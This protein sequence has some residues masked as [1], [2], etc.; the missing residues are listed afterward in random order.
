MENNQETYYNL[1]TE[2]LNKLKFEDIDSYP[3]KFYHDG[4]TMMSTQEF[5]DK[6]NGTES[7]QHL[8]SELVALVGRVYS[9]RA[10][11]K[12]LYFIDLHDSGIRVQMMMNSK[13][14]GDSCS[15]VIK[16]LKKESMDTSKH[17][18]LM[19]SVVRVGDNVGVVGYVFKT[20]RGELSLM[21]HNMT[22]LSPCMYMIPPKHVETT[23]GAHVK[24][25]V[26]PE[27][28]FRQRYLDLI[29]N[30]ENMEIFIRRSKIIKFI[31]RF[32][33]DMDFLEVDTPV[34]NMTVGGANAKPFA[35]HSNDFNR[36]MF[37]RIAPEL[38][39]K[40]LVIGGYNRVYE[41]GR[42]FRNEGNDLTH[43]SEF[44]SMECYMKNFD[45]NDLMEFGEKMF[46][47][48]VLQMNGSY[49]V[50]Y[51]GKEIDFTPPF[52]RIDM[53][54]KLKELTGM[55]MPSD[56]STTEARDT[57][58]NY[59]KKLGVDCSNPRTTPRLIDKLVGHFIEP[60][61]VNPTFITNHPLIMSPLAKQ[62]RD[63]QN[64]TERF[65]LF[66]NC[67]E[68]ANAYT[69]LNDPNIQKQRFAEQTKDKEM[70]DDE[71][72]VLD[73]DF[74]LALEYGLPPTG[75]FGVG[76][77]RLCMLLNDCT[78]IREVILFPTMKPV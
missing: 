18:E 52:K 16:N 65:E 32:L 44:T 69:E 9:I 43:N 14:Y 17:F 19:T 46:A 27:I 53:L 21:I 25:L 49:L 57:L 42:Q 6:Y 38:Y 54:E 30:E 34:L 64:I 12:N 40:Q 76:I 7:K 60:L 3:H 55:E 4:Y 63:N 37:M 11:G 10:Q 73:K 35:T 47:G 66:I 29:V 22:L 13:T 1:R 74:V 67:M 39:L 24:S 72:M 75:G 15:N 56:L 33:E 58:D 41:L 26:D 36:E 51:N 50:K 59:C 77:D 71:A 61:C 45:Y 48:L 20:P 31:R 2:D 70:G 78:S 23:T 62:H 5:I 68:F 28:R 8:T